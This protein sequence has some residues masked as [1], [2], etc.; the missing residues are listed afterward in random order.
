MGSKRLM[1]RNYRRWRL[2]MLVVLVVLMN[3]KLMLLHLGLLLDLRRGEMGW[4]YM[5]CR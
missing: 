2:M 5:C 4:Q 3:L 1:L